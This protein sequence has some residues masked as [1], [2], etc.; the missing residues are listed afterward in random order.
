M[1]EQLPL[2]E[3][4]QPL[5]CKPAVVCAAGCCGMSGGTSH[6]SSTGKP[7]AACRTSRWQD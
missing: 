2:L 5:L 4:H 1:L 3:H 6:C 7:E